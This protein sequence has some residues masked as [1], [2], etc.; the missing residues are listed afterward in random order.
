MAATGQ[1]VFVDGSKERVHLFAAIMLSI[2]AF[3]LNMERERAA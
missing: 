2:A 1:S 3:S